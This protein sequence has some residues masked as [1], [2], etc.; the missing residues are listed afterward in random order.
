MEF[1][2][3]PYGPLVEVI[4]PAPQSTQLKADNAAAALSELHHKYPDLA[5]WK[6][7]IACAQGDRV[8]AADDKLDPNIE[9]ALIPP[10][11]GG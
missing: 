2:L 3:L 9:L 10:V 4:G 7:R 5:P 1:T 8:L 6:G 11:S